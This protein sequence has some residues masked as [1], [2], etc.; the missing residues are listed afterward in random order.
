M[1]TA[2]IRDAALRL[3]PEEKARLAE[4]LL[5][6]L[7]APDRAAIDAEWGAAA[8]RR[9]DELDAGKTTAIPADDVF[10]D[11]EARRQ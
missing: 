8:E 5:A 10:R 4:E 11:L 7:D 3:T 1:S 2:E 9:V 6:S